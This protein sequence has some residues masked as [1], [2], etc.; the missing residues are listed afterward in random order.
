MESLAERHR[1][2][3]KIKWH[4]FEQENMMVFLF[5]IYLVF[6]KTHIL[7]VEWKHKKKLI[8]KKQA[9]LTILIIQVTQNYWNR[10]ISNF[11]PIRCDLQLIWKK[12]K[13]IEW[14]QNQWRKQEFFQITHFWTEKYE[15]YIFGFLIHI[16]C[17]NG[18]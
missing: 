13:N 8:L 12:L 4:I 7:L 15:G 1:I 10:Y 9:D 3:E 11:H 18:S 14:E 6:V 16:D 2:N 5:S 17:R